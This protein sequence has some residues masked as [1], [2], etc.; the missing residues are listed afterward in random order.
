M[1]LSFASRTDFFTFPVRLLFIALIVTAVVQ[2]LKLFLPRINGWVAVIVNLIVTG[3]GIFYLLG[4]EITTLPLIIMVA[5]CAAGMHGTST[6]LA[7]HLSSKDNPTPSGY[8][9]EDGDK[10]K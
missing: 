8:E 2:T 9:R 6:K 10:I 3:Y 7:D 5:L 1:L 4:H